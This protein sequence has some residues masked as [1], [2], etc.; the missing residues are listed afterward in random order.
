[1][2]SEDAPSV[3]APRASECSQSKK[4]KLMSLLTKTFLW[5]SKFYLTRINCGFFVQWWWRERALDTRWGD[6]QASHEGALQKEPVA[7]RIRHWRGAKRWVEGD[8]GL[9]ETSQ[10]IHRW[11]TH[12]QIQVQL[13]DRKHSWSEGDQEKCGGWGEGDQCFQEYPVCAVSERRRV[14]TTVLCAGCLLWLGPPQ[15]GFEQD[16]ARDNAERR[17]RA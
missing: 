7:R 4:N 9:M 16:P 10:G 5:L 2:G 8:G 11:H 13:T 1:M 15:S 3:P 6:G 12:K 14:Q 17:A